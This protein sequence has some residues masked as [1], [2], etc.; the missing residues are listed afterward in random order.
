MSPCWVEELEGGAHG[1]MLWRRVPP[2]EWYFFAGVWWWWSAADGRYMRGGGDRSVR[3]YKGTYW[4]ASAWVPPEHPEA[5][6]PWTE[7]PPEDPE[8]EDPWTEVLT[9]ALRLR[10]LQLR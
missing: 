8:E 2:A 6:D 10:E 4:V 3:W 5:E 1:F 9:G 7:V